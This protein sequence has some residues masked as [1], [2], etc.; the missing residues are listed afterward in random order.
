MPS[1]AFKEWAGARLAALDEIESAH[2]TVGGT[3]PGRRYATQQLN[4]SYAVMLASHFQAFCREL[5][6]EC[7]FYLVA[8]VAALNLRTMLRNNLVFGRR[9]DRGNPNPG[10]VGADFNRF[11]LPCW[12]SVDAH[13]AGNPQRRALLG[14]LI[15]W[16][17]AI[18]H[19]DFGAIVAGGGCASVQ[20]AQVQAWRKAREGLAHSFDRVLSGH[21]QTMTGVVPW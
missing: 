5:H 21:I 3:G 19:Q 15:A 2:R 6:T 17:N 8:P 11:D 12:P 7:A 10:N 13:H 20:L 18:A 4:Q 1:N 9:L 16:R 14:D